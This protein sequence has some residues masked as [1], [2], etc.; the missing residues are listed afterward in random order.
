MW[1]RLVQFETVAIAFIFLA[2]GC[3]S[4]DLGGENDADS[5]SADAH[6]YANFNDVRVKH[7]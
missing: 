1:N 7:I 6:T 3:S 2:M 5:L 4:I